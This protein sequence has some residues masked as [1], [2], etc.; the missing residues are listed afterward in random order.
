MIGEV[1]VLLRDQLNAYLSAKSG[2]APGDPSEAK[3]VLLDG[4]KADPIG[5]KLGA[6]TA[7]L[8]NIEQETTLRPANPYVRP[9]PGGSSLRI[10]PEIRL[11]LYVLFVANFKQYEQGLSYLSLIISYFQGHRV[12]DHQ[13]VPA[14]SDRLDRLIVELVTLPLS[15]QNEIWSS[16][17]TTSRPNVLYRVGMVIFADEESLPVAEVQEKSITIAQ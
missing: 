9:L 17:R 12:L 2:W 13:N 5:F 15:E 8:V 6:V 1:L 10:Q 3:V 11:N 7:L 16:L 14:M 4:E